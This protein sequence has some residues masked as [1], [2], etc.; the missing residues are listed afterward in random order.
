MNGW[1]LPD[2]FLAYTAHCIKHLLR[3]E[4]AYLC[5]PWCTYCVVV[6]PVEFWNVV[7]PWSTIASLTKLG[8]E[9]FSL[10]DAWRNLSV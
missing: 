8:V 6:F 1:I 5:D 10:F 7:T 9:W 2:E 4:P 3:G